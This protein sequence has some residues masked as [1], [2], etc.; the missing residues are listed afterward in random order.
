MDRQTHGWVTGH[1][2]L[3]LLEAKKAFKQIRFDDRTEQRKPV[4]S[5]ETLARYLGEALV[6]WKAAR[7]FMNKEFG[8]H[9]NE[10]IDAAKEPSQR[11]LVDDRD[12]D[13]FVYMSSTQWFNLESPVGRRSAL[14]HILALVSWHHER[15][16]MD[17]DDSFDSEDDRDLMDENA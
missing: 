8:S 6:S 4:V 11:M 10:Y 15:D 9:Y 12:K 13:T 3:A 17:S 5:N 14:C 1:P 2:Y 7:H 16:A